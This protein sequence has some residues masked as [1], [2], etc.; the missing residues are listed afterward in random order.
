MI[1]GD[2]RSAFFLSWKP[3]GKPLISRQNEYTVYTFEQKGANVC[4]NGL[5][6]K[7]I[8]ELGGEIP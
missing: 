5:R 7:G 1:F 2:V 4:M 3:F 8:L 6:E